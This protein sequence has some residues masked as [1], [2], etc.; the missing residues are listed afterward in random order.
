MTL[1]VRRTHSKNGEVAGSLRRLVLGSILLVG[2]LIAVFPL[3]SMAIYATHDRGT[4]LSAPPPLWIGE[5]S[6]Q[7][8]R[9]LVE[10]R[11]FWRSIWNSLYIAAL[12]TV[13]TLFFCSLAGYAFAMYD[14]KGKG[15]LFTI[16]LGTLFVPQLLGI[17]PWFLIIDALGWLN[18]PRALWI[19]G[20]ASAFG[21][22]LMRQYIA[23]GIHRDLLDAARIDG[24]S[25]FRIYWNVVVPLI[26]PAF[27]TLGLISFVASWN[28]FLGALIVL[29]TP[30]TAT[31]P[32]TLRS[33]QAL[34]NTEWGA[35][36]MG[37]AIS[38][39]PLLLVFVLASRQFIA[40]LTAGAVKA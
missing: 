20:M 13:A 7:N 37:S 9:I 15:L 31:F 32:V 39:F 40:G 21:I 30:D 11:P 6:A 34:I 19:P 33:L 24:C 3:Y 5:Q 8:Y 26:T 16:L 35:V 23:S 18:Q 22:F 14:F 2:A 29:R 27:G 12:G 1:A 4:I 36:M 17:V 25:E 10:T 38:V 28:S